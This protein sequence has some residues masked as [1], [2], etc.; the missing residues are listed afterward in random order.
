MFISLNTLG[1][2]QSSKWN[3]TL[4]DAEYK[5]SPLGLQYIIILKATWITGVFCEQLLRQQDGQSWTTNI[6]IS[7]QVPYFIFPSDC[8]IC[9]VHAPNVHI[10]IV[11]KSITFKDLK[12]STQNI[13]QFIY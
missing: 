6:R 8:S 5:L 2:L 3:R 13:Y 12:M 4:C 7:Y 10:K 11:L 9:W 1:F